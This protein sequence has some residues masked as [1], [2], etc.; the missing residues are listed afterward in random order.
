MQAQANPRP[1]SLATNPSRI[2]DANGSTVA[3]LTPLDIPNAEM[4]LA[5]VNACD[6]IAPEKLAGRTLAEYVAN[7]AYLRG[8]DVTQVGVESSI[9][10]LASQMLAASFAGEFKGSGAVNFL[11]FTFH[12]AE[13]GEVTV[14]MQR[15]QGKTPGQLKAEAEAERDQLRAV[16]A[17]AYQ[18]AGMLDAPVEAL[19]NLI[20]AANGEPLPHETFLPVAVPDVAEQ[21]DALL[22][23]AIYVRKHIRADSPWDCKMARV[24][25]RAISKIDPLFSRTLVIHEAA[26]RLRAVPSDLEIVE[27]NQ[28]F[29]TTAGP[30]SG[31]GGCAM[32]AFPVIGFKSPSG[33]GVMWCD[34]LW[35]TWAPPFEQTWGPILPDEEG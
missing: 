32:T 11:E 30:H 33:Y 19:D 26:A 20:A 24:L 29:G 9:T 14:T 12:H 13:L 31:V 10:G 17:E 4:I 6:G 5:C 18:L 23:A 1:W 3:K 25:D 27:W 34:G 2:V 22:D 28:M 16:C 35:R 21:R 7:E 15:T 8:L